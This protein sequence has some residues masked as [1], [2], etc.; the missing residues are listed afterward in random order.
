MPQSGGLPA[1]EL[2]KHLSNYSR[3]AYDDSAF[4]IIE[5]S[6]GCPETSYS[7]IEKEI[8]R[9]LDPDDHKMGHIYAYEVPHN[10]GYVKIGYTT[11]TVEKR[12]KEWKLGCNRVP[13]VLFPKPSSTVVLIPHAR[14][15]E[16][17]CHAELGHR[18]IRIYC[19]NCLK[20]HLEWFE[21]PAAEAVAAIKKWS[22][23][24]ASCPYELT[25]EGKSTIKR[26]ERKKMLDMGCFMREISEN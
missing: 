20:Q 13:K 24:M 18:R 10:P 2:L 9:D 8:L 26:K 5:K 4:Q 6:D 11:S 3:T 1:S 7:S 22:K 25:S 17:L 15:V 23:W 12:L 19:K 14:R 16:A 21:T